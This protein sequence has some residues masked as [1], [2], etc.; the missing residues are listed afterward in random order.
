MSLKLHVVRRIFWSTQKLGRCEPQKVMKF[1]LCPHTS[2]LRHITGGSTQ[3]SAPRPQHS[4]AKETS[5]EE[6]IICGLPCSQSDCGRGPLV[7]LE[8]ERSFLFP[9]IYLFLKPG[10]EFIL[11]S[12]LTL[13]DPCTPSLWDQSFYWKLTAGVLSFFHFNHCD[14]PPCKNGIWG[15]L[16]PV[17]QET[18]LFWMVS[19]G[20]HRSVW[21]R[22]RNNQD[23]RLGSSWFLICTCSVEPELLASKKEAIS[24]KAHY[25]RGEPLGNLLVAMSGVWTRA[26]NVQMI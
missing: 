20:F 4:R 11:G 26:Y 19:G 22:S 2:L 15:P 1:W 17:I 21:R 3:I 16:A 7:F 5:K 12:S 9:D 18:M 10:F 23:M 8:R 13:W 24:L 14:I 6:K 25:D